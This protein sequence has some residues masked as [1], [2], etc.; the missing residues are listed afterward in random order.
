M[1]LTKTILSNSQGVQWTFRL[2]EFSAIFEDH[3]PGP[4]YLRGLTNC[5]RTSAT[6]LARVPGKGGVRRELVPFAIFM[7]PAMLPLLSFDQ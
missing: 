2:F 3:I 7:P 4:I 5:S 1:S 6:D